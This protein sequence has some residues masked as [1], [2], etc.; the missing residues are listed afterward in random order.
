MRCRY[1]IRLIGIALH[2]GWCGS[3]LDAIPSRRND[4]FLGF[5]GIKSTI[6]WHEC[7]RLGWSIKLS[8]EC[9]ECHFIE[10]SLLSH[11]EVGRPLYRHLFQ[12]GQPRLEVLEQD[13]LIARQFHSVASSLPEPNDPQQEALQR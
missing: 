13:L 5:Y 2:G 11:Q 9:N 1:I 10:P 6:K 4:A 7:R 3:I 12:F 8:I